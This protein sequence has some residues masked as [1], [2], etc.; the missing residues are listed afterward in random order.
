MLLVGLVAYFIG[1]EFGWH[2]C[3]E[4]LYNPL[5]EEYKKQLA[6]ESQARLEKVKQSIVTK[7]AKLTKKQGRV[8]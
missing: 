4:T 2:Q 3:N 7:K 5:L 1:H 6:K 8:K